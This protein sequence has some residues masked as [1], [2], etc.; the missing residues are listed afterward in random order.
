MSE[1]TFKFIFINYWRSIDKKILFCFLILFFLGLFFSF[2][3]TSPLAGER[4]NKD[5]YFFFTKHLIFTLIAL[6]VMML[7]SI[8]KTELLIHLIIPLFI[9]SFLSLALVPI[10]GIEVKGAK[11][12]LDL[13]FFRLQPIEIL[14][15]LFILA[16]VRILTLKKFE[17][18]QIKYIL[19]FILLSSVII[20]LI[21]QP[22]LGQTVL[23]ICCWIATVFISGVSLIYLFMFFSI[24]IISI[25]SL[26]F[27]LPE[28]FGYIINRLTAFLDP[29]QGDKFQST[30][31]LDAIKLGGLTGQGMGEGILKE[32]VPEAHT[33]YVIAVISE[34]FGSIVSIMIMIIFLY[35]SFRIIKNCFNQDNKYIKISLSGLATLLIF[36]TFIHAGVNTNLLPTTGMTLPF[37]SYGGSSLIGSAILAGLILNYTKNKVYLYD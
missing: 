18:S 2:S 26:L 22:D 8:V 31:A 11:R 16:T 24:F 36:Q 14:K 6:S 37:L 3:S 28:K 5:Y 35:I 17:D 29:H 15:P 30:S 20:L 9:I 23:L 1:N 33:D 10:I 12:W 7:I 27:F 21:D 25:G 4:L 13:Y 32:S 34:E 19:S